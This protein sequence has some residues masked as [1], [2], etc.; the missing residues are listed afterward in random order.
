MVCQT[1]NPISQL[2][3][4]PPFK[5]KDENEHSGSLES[6]RCLRH[7]LNLPGAGEKIHLYRTLGTAVNEVQVTNS[8][9][10]IN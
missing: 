9:R 4:K 2:H 10:M 1:D 3:D 7:E 6:S 5:L 8:L